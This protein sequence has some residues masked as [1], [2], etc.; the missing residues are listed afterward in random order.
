M[1]REGRLIWS[2]HWA[3]LRMNRSAQLLFNR[4]TWVEYG[5]LWNTE[6]F[7][8]QW[9]ERKSSLLAVSNTN[10]LFS[11]KGMLRLMVDTQMERS[12]AAVSK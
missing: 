2:L 4:D 1:S 7:F 11:W 5:R 8:A 12:L 10:W 6:I 3:R 9:M